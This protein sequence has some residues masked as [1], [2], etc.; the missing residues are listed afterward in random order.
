MSSSSTDPSTAAIWRAA[1]GPLVV[2]LVVLL[3]GLLLSLAAGG[4][5]GRALDPRSAAAGGGRALATLLREQGV[6]VDRVTTTAAMAADARRGDTVLVVD[7]DLLADPQVEVARSTGA[8]LVLVSVT[9]PGRYLPGVTADAT[10]AGVRSPGCDL[11][12]ARR[13]GRADAGVLAYDTSG[14][15]AA[16]AV[17]CY[18]RDGRGSLVVADVDSAAVTLLGSGSALT[19]G[20]LDD[21]G[22]AALAL[23]LLGARP[24]LVWYLPSLSDLPAGSGS[25]FYSLVPPGVWWALV[26]LA[27][28]VLLLALW[29][30]RRLGP[31]VAEPLPVVVRAAEAVEGRARLYRRTGSRGTAAEALRAAARNRLVV[32]TGLPRRAG[33]PEVVATVAARAGRPAAGPGSVTHLLY[34]AEP[35]DDGGLVRL[36]DEIDRLEREVRRS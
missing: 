9:E 34:G 30:A 32:A 13:A 4:D 35:A 6:Q 26:Q 25:T 29:R 27:V 33:R 18:S 2:L 8:D 14:T 15:L 24:H 3:A 1:R 20:R 7:P 19:N 5:S 36:A 16:D 21:E 10:G 12:A 23:A 11:P 31:V 22:N 28:A 17:G